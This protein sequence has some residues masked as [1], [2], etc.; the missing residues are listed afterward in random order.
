MNISLIG[1]MGAGKTSVGK[2][3]AKRLSMEFIDIDS[4]IEENEN[5]TIN[6]IFA[7]KGEEY[8]RKLETQAINLICSKD[9]Q[10]ISTGGGAVQDTDNLDILK[11]NSKVV[12][13]KAIAKTLYERIKNET[14]R[15][16]LKVENPLKKLEELLVNR[17]ENY[18]KADIVVDTEDKD[19][20]EILKNILSNID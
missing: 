6:E 20:Q 7:S 10:V 8:F 4:F 5:I 9:N 3:L 16:L 19:V 12:Y 1:L 14:N 15:P 13:L 18:L 11:R 17:E 2:V